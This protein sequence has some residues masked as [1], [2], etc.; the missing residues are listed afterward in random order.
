MNI[1]VDTSVVLAV[2]TNQ[3]HRQRLI[4]LT[5]SADLLSPPSLPWKIGDAFSAMFKRGR[6]ALSQTKRALEAYGRIPIRLS[7]VGLNRAIE[8]SKDL[9]IYAYDA[10]TIGCAQKHNCPI[11]SLDRALL[12]AARRAD[13]K[14]LE[15]EV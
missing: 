13:V 5:R 7:D 2:I 4:S 1:V 12:V 14:T 10:Y 9:A 3:P 15:V 6:I 8:L 11:I